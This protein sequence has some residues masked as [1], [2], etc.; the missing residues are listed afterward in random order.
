MTTV[1]PNRQRPFPMPD[2]ARVVYDYVYSMT[3]PN[4]RGLGKHRR[5]TAATI[6]GANG[7][8]IATGF[9]MCNPSD[10][11]NKRIGRDIARGRALKR[12]SNL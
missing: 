3:T 6:Y 5:S 12:L 10:Q 8:I 1:S 9:A 11:F 2:G 4:G 7:D